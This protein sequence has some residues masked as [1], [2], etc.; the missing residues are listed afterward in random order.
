M[1]VGLR[2]DFLWYPI[3]TSDFV[4]SFFST[5]CYNLENGDWGSKFP[6][7]MKKL[8]QGEVSFQNISEAN[9][10]LLIIRDEL[11]KFSP[12]AMVWDIEDLTLQPPWGKKI[13]KDI[14]DLSNYFITCDGED[15]FDELFKAFHEARI[16]KQS[17]VLESL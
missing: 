9:N 16:E 11:K 2:V 4:H 7:I 17:V 6:Y 10:E 5:I 15:L 3:G 13:S 1:S 12:S 8:Y 14:T